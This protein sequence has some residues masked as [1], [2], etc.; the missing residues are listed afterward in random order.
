MENHSLLALIQKT[1]TNYKSEVTKF[2]TSSKKKRAHNLYQLIATAKN[3]AQLKR[4]LLFKKI[5]LKTYSEK[6][7]YLWRNELRVLKDELE[8][9]YIQHEHAVHVKNN[10]AYTDWLLV[11]AYDRIKFQDGIA[12]KAQ[13]LQQSKDF[14]AAY[15]Y[16]LDAKMIEVINLQNVYGNFKQIIE[17]YPQAVKECVDGLNHLVAYYQGRINLFIAQYNFI[18]GQH[19]K[20]HLSPLPPEYNC[21]LP[22]NPISKFYQ[23]YAD[24]HGDN[25]DVKIEN[26]QKAITSISPIALNNKLYEY[27][28]V[29]VVL[30]LAR[31]LSANGHYEKAH[32]EFVRI[33]QSIDEKFAL[34][35]T[36]FYVNYTMNL[37]KSKKY[38]EALFA[39]DNEYTEEHPMFKNM[40]LQNRMVCYLNLR[41]TQ[42]LSK[43]IS[44][45]LDSAPFPLNY[46]LK[47]IKSVYFYLVKEYDLALNIVSNLLNTKDAADRL[48]EYQPIAHIFKKLYTTT[49]K[50]MLLKKWKSED[51]KILRTAVQ[52]F[53]QTAHP[54]IKFVAVYQWVKTEIEQHLAN[55]SI[56][57]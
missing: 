41:D 4:E 31:E 2:W 54:E 23:F 33:K 11:Q 37:V 24:S 8:R 49:Q 39:L 3:E 50:N 19:D 53:E 22:Q 30:S 32:E 6:N 13:S 16:A 56:N 29:L 28:Q 26:L 47:L 12:E 1:E 15:N 14:T 17:R 20:V 52:E 40:L 34:F 27:N 9:F 57:T 51:V 25:Y 48:Q 45:D 7:D 42:N 44:S 36:A 5:F 43:Y 38:E 10:P 55:S 18:F 21:S 46:M 35:K